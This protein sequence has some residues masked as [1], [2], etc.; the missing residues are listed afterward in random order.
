LLQ[1]VRRWLATEAG[2][3]V[4]LGVMAGLLLAPTLARPQPSAP[5]PPPAAASR[6]RTPLQAM[7][8][9]LRAAADETT[10][11]RPVEASPLPTPAGDAEGGSTSG[12]PI[13]QYTIVSGD[14]L[15]GIAE[16][17]HTDVRSLEATNGL[18]DN[19]V[20]QPGQSLV[21]PTTIGWV[22]SVTAGDTLEHIAGLAGL[23]VD[24]VAAANHLT[25]DSVLQIGQ[26]LWIPHEP[27]AVQVAVR[28][29]VTAAS[30]GSTTA[31]SQ[32][33]PAAG[34]IWPVRGPITS[35]FGWR[36]LYGRQD[37]HD[38]I[39]IAVPMYTPVRAATSGRVVTA[40]WD[41]PYGIAVR[42][43]SGDVITLYGHNSRVAVQAGQW[44]DQGQVIAYSG[45]TGNATGPHVH[46]GVY[47]NGRAVNPLDYLP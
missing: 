20:L 2:R 47:V 44:V 35:G 13:V 27:P 40:G 25:T 1:G 17:F 46:F 7:N 22:Y 21:V 36:L 8:G 11:E 3:R 23:S 31:A 30:G 32:A 4:L 45:M 18:S 33:T 43:A 6:P 15:S 12:L 28:S 37:F 19:S 26:R 38:G 29:G 16:R 10:L 14:T 39:D 41:G 5:A 34:F 9:L 42:I 24:A